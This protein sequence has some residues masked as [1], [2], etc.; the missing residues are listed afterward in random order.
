MPLVNDEN[1]VKELKGEISQIKNKLL[2]EISIYTAKAKEVAKDAEQLEKDIDSVF[3]PV[4]NPKKAWSLSSLFTSPSSE[5]DSNL[6][7]SEDDNQAW[8]NVSA[9]VS[10]IKEKISQVALTHSKKEV[11]VAAKK[12]QQPTTLRY[13]KY[14]L[15]ETEELMKEIQQNIN[16]IDVM[17]KDIDQKF[18]PKKM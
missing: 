13:P 7:L 16:E 4:K 14:M 10:G 11:P 5:F 6:S 17:I 15:D 18:A 8:K 1:K 9:K 12:E 3:K 2:K